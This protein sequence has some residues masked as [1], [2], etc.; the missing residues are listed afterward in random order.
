MCIL[1]ITY[2]YYHPFADPLFLTHG[3]TGTLNLKSLRS[4]LYIHTSP[5]A[6]KLLFSCGGTTE[7]LTVKEPHNLQQPSNADQ[8]E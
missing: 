8:T 6:D 7:K 5:S 3:W 1:L 4:Q 2:Y